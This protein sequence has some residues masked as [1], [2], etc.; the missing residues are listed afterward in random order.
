MIYIVIYTDV[1]D[2]NFPIY[3]TAV[4]TTVIILYITSL[5]VSY[6][7]TGSLYFL[8]TFLQF[9]LPPTLVTFFWN[10]LILW[11]YFKLW[12]ADLYN[13]NIQTH[14]KYSI[15]DLL[16]LD[17]MTEVIVFNLPL[18]ISHI[19]LAFMAKPAHQINV[20]TKYSISLSSMPHSWLKLIALS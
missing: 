20:A 11:L 16:N 1:Y 13:F 15:N 3:H 4:L 19:L 18:T 10:F 6:L 9:S 8:N 5:V 7:V 2:I 17:L 14:S 12:L